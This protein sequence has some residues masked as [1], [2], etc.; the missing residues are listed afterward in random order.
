MMFYDYLGQKID[1]GN[2]NTSSKVGLGDLSG[3]I[4]NKV[5]C[6]DENTPVI[7]LLDISKVEIGRVTNGVYGK[8]FTDYRVSDYI[9][10]NAGQCY[11]AMSWD[12]SGTTTYDRVELFD[13]D[14]QFV[15]TFHT[16]GNGTI[17]YC[18]FTPEITG[19]VRYSYTYSEQANPMVYIGV[20]TTDEYVEYTGETL[21]GDVKYEIAK[22][23]KG[24][25]RRDVEPS[26]IYGKTVYI[27]GDSNS[28]NWSG[29]SSKA[30]EKRY[31]CKV[32]GLGKYGATWATDSDETDTRSSNAIGQ[33]NAFVSAVGIGEDTYTFPDDVVL[34]FMM[35]TN[36]GSGVF[37]PNNEDV[38]TPGGAIN[39]IFKRARYYGR[40]ISIGVFLP[41]CAVGNEELQKAAEH[42]KIP[43]FDIPAIIADDTVTAGLT[44]PDG[45]IV[46]NN[47]ISDGGNHLAKWG[48]KTFERIAHP[49]IAY[50]I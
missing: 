20:A 41:W 49:W 26:N 45:S 30:L 8:Y 38:T 46:G 47:F 14:K 48:W 1:I 5:I 29:G 23:F 3:E 18:L 7:N 36:V 17:R 28:D 27:I 6:V 40:N 32:I 22:E 43:Y 10:V 15:Q 9:P 16:D 39:Y 19:F 50:R 25:L 33:W 24:V 37:D 42:Y 44:R 12:A 21:T 2:N 13:T 34:L 31:G 35:G 4:I 11:V